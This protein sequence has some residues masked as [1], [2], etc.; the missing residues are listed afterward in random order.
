MDQIRSIFLGTGNTRVVISCLMDETFHDK[1]TSA[2]Y[3]CL[4]VTRTRPNYY[5]CGTGNISPLTSM[6]K[7]ELKYSQNYLPRFTLE[8]VFKRRPYFVKFRIQFKV[9]NILKNVSSVKFFSYVY[10]SHRY[11]GMKIYDFIM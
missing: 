9:V 3:I 11:P 5:F 7:S 4:I 10:I 8:N 1:I 6:E 2:L